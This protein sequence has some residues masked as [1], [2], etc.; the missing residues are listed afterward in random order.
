MSRNPNIPDR[1]PA[2]RPTNSPQ[3]SISDG[4]ASQG[5]PPSL[6]GQVEGGNGQLAR[7][8]EAGLLRSRRRNSRRWKL[9]LRIPTNWQFWGA[10]TVVLS[11][12]I[13]FYS[14]GML[15]KLPALPDCPE[16]FWPM[17]S[18]SSRLYCAQT[19]ASKQTVRGLLDAIAL[20]EG[21]P[22]DDPMRNEINRNIEEWSTEVLDLAEEGFNAG[23]LQE[24]IATAKKIPTHVSAYKLVKDR[25]ERWQTIWAK[26]EE[27]YRQVEGDLES[28]HWHDAFMKANR[29]SAVANKYWSTTKYEELTAKIQ[30]AQQD[31][32]KL[33]KAQDLIKSGGLDNLLSAINLAEEISPQS[34]VY[35]KAKTTIAELSN[36]L[37][38]LAKDNLDQRNWQRVLEIANRIPASLDLQAETQDLIDLARAQ[39]RAE[40]GNISSLEAAIAEVQKI[41]ASRP[42]YAKAQE[43]RTRWQREIEDVAHLERSRE[44]A[45]AGGGSDISAAISEAQLISSTNPRYQEAQ[46]QI[47]RWRNE[48][49]TREDR[50]YLDRAQS[51]ASGGDVAALQAAIEEANKIGSGRALYQEARNNINQWTNRIQITQDRPYLAQAES[52]AN[53]G[54]LNGAIATAEQVREG[55]ALYREAQS[56]VRSW[57]Q[58][59]QGEQ[60][61][62]SASQLAR[63]GTPESLTAAIQSAR[64]VPGSSRQS[65]EAKTAIDGWSEQLLSLAQGRA[66]S[67]LNE[68]IAI[69]RNIPSG[70]SAYRN[71]Q[72]QIK[73][74]EKALAP[75]SPTTSPTVIN[76]SN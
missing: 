47:Q 56:K 14:V 13:G 52:L 40:I 2:R 21:L 74:W 15:L 70:T 76:T 16:V 9:N 10:I 28:L 72:N 3:G 67:N 36:R 19:S 75:P 45:K 11:G 5:L 51:L 34:Y 54:N 39:A 30:T 22:E 6:P 58:E 41:E 73:E 20:L 25:I 66:A 42:F 57:R 68:A 69:A 24:A 50:P 60:A 4:N 49:E 37:I 29:L 17:A 48:I 26:A 1:W 71:A 65:S 23:N 59:I 32:S 8:G 18:V 44:L 12:G 62:Q 7:T 63:S 38:Q 46:K 33:D 35:S 43:L 55:R 53:A 27:I 61:L 64:Q 31:S